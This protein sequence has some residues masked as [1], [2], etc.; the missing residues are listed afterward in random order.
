MKK[1]G[2]IKEKTI[3]KFRQIKTKSGTPFLYMRGGIFTPNTRKKVLGIM[4]QPEPGMSTNQFWYKRRNDVERALIDLRLFIEVAGKDNVNQIITQE[5]LR[6]IVE[7]LLW[8]PVV[9]HAAPDLNLA[10]I[11][12]L[13]IEVGFSYLRG[14]GHNVPLSSQRTIEEAIDLSNYLVSEVEAL[15]KAVRERRER[16]ATLVSDEPSDKSE[17]EGI[18]P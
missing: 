1:E 8:H 15:R 14:I 4:K 18:K 6:P 12:Q 7:A 17:N 9:H 13:L 5:S 16:L 3:V 11:A 10:E 2:T